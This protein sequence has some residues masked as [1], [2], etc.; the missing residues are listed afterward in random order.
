MGYTIALLCA[1]FEVSRTSYYNFARGRSYNLEK[2]YSRPRH[3]IRMEFLRNMKRYGLRRIQ[4]SLALR[5]IKLGRRTVSRLMKEEGLIAIQPRSFIPRTTDSKHGKRVCENLLLGMQKPS[6]PNAVWVSDIT[7][8]PLKGGK[9]EYLSAWQDLVY[10]RNSWLGSS[11]A[12]E[13]GFST[14]AIGEGIIEKEC[15]KGNDYSLRQRWS[16]FVCQS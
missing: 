3:E 14:R 9:W 13:G 11:G 4:A 7:Y 16:I 10:S 8:I 1:V 12:Y 5:Q 15:P 2:K 6:V